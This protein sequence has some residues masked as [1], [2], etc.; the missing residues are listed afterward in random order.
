M[1]TF[2]TNWCRNGVNG[3]I[4]MVP[5]CVVWY[6]LIGGSHDSA[7]KRINCIRFDF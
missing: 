5:Y 7:M 6:N 2:S 3:E 1:F 4:A